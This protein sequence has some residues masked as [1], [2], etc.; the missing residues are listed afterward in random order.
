VLV[1]YKPFLTPLEQV[2]INDL[3]DLDP[4]LCSIGEAVCSLTRVVLSMQ[5]LRDTR[6]VPGMLFSPRLLLYS[7]SN[8]DFAYSLERMS[9]IAK[10]EDALDRLDL[11]VIGQHD[12]TPALPIFSNGLVS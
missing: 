4:V 9:G 8:Q 12:P 1:L 7:L 5:N 11:R 10:M 2:R 6:N 3:W